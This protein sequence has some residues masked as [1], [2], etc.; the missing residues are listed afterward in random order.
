MLT[1][2]RRRNKGREGCLS[3]C[4]GVQREGCS[5]RKGKDGGAVLGS[6]TKILGIMVRLDDRIGVGIGMGI[7]KRGMEIGVIERG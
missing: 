3:T 5:K 4:K 1:G 7:M 2:P 6:K